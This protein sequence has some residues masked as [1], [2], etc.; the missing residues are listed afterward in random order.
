MAMPRK[1]NSFLLALGLLVLAAFLCCCGGEQEGAP[2]IA[3]K[4]VGEAPHEVSS[5][6]QGYLIHDGVLWESAGKWKESKLKKIDLKTRQVITERKI[7]DELFAEGL[8]LLGDKLYQLTWKE[9]VCLVWNASSMIRTQ[10]FKYRGQGWGLTT[11]GKELVMSDGSA[12]LVFRRPDDFGEIRRVRVTDGSNTVPALNELEW[13]EGE[14]WANVY[15]QDRIAIINPATGAVRAWLDCGEL[16]KN[17]DHPEAEV[18][19]G[20][21]YDAATKEIWLTGKYWP[22]S[23]RIALEN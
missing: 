11:D 19:N 14:V 22:K 7:D 8:C 17:F 16:R 5:Y 20:I 18:L 21:A 12:T 3:F 10:T 23:F 1:S 2:T 15:Q 6:C 13:I 4:V 9:G